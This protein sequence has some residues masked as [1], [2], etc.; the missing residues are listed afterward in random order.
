MVR[1]VMRVE[2]IRTSTAIAIAIAIARATPNGYV[3]VIGV[4]QDSA[5]DNHP[6]RPSPK[7]SGIR[8]PIKRKLFQ[9]K[10][11]VKFRVTHQ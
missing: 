11:A 6:Q 8:N 10:A 2:Y 1:T 4:V 7:H 5:P 9:Q 3:G